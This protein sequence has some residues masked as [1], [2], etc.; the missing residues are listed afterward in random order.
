MSARHHPAL[1]CL[2]LG[3]LAAPPAEAVV[4]GEISRNPD[5]LRR[6]VVRVE[7]SGGELCSGV[8]I[9]AN[10]VL[11]AAHCVVDRAAYRV[12]GV[13]R[14]FRSRAVRVVAAT[15]HPTFVHG[16]TPRTQPGV[17]LALLQLE[18]PLGAGFEPFDI[19]RSSRVSTGDVVTLAGY[20]VSAERVKR[21]ARTLRETRLI[22]LGPVQVRN[23]VLVVADQ[24]RLAET[25][26]SGACRGDSGGP[27][28]LESRSGLH[29]VGVVSW[30]SGAI[31]SRQATA[32]GGL[33]A[34]TPV[35]DHLGWIAEA[36]SALTGHSPRPDAGSLANG[37]DWMNRR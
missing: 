33:T 9:R 28:A 26:G 27:I 2:V 35:S 36:A 37:S 1:A 29:L 12:I 32:C 30:S 13:E 4:R 25:S 23:R 22:A 16:T 31:G 10:V 7:N 5:G 14:S 34:V 19:A 20:G 17:D 15:V 18:R 3:M 11:T 21:S 8:L 24:E 6:A